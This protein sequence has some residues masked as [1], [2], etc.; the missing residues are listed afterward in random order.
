MS[1]E[2]TTLAISVPKSRHPELAEMRGRRAMVD[3]QIYYMQ[4]NREAIYYMQANREATL[5]CLWQ[6]QRSAG[7]ASNE[8]SLV[9]YMIT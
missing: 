8:Q 9:V 1:A 4:A 5:G 7:R 6:K 2:A 3:S